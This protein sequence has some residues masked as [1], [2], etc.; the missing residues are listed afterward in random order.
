[1]SIAN[2]F[3]TI[4]CKRIRELTLVLDEEGCQY[5]EHIMNKYIN[6]SDRVIESKPAAFAQVILNHL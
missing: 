3:R 5:L 2:R 1:M 6:D 4:S